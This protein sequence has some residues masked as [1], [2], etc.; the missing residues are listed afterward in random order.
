MDVNNIPIIII[1]YNRKTLLKNLVEYFLNIGETN[2]IIIDN[3]SSYQPLLDWFNEIEN[4]E[5]VKIHKLNHNYGHTV[6]WESGLFTDL[7]NNNYY[8]LTDHDIIPYNNFKPGWKQD[9]IDLLNKYNL[10][11]IGSAISITDIPDHYKLKNDVITHENSFW[12]NEV[13]PNIFKADI[14]TTLALYKKGCPYVYGP[15]MR[16]KEYEIKHQ[17]WYID[18]SNLSEEDHYY[19]NNLKKSTHWSRQQL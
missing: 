13:E 18:N 11:K 15:S 4:N 1:S 19:L 6:L 8:I 14:D 12:I 9:W 10:N 16:L 5:S 17:P 3:N 2:I 7:I